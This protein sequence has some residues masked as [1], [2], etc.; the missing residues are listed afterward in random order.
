MSSEPLRLGWIGLGSMGFA[1]ALNIQK[2][3]QTHK[4]PPLHCWNRTISRGDPLR[5]FGSVLCESVA[6]VVQNSDVIFISV[7]ND[8]ALKSVV[9]DII[10]SG[11]IK[12]KI[13]VDTTTVH[14]NTSA[15]T[16]A[17]FRD[18][19]ADYIA[20]PVFGATPLAQAG[21]L[22]I[23]VAGPPTS[24]ALIRPFLAG[25]TARAV[26]DVGPVPQ[27]ALLLK[28]TSN[29]LTAGLMYLLSEAHT[30]AEK[31]G[32]PAAV[33]ESLVEQNFGAYAHG[34]S[35]RMTGGAY[36]PAE[37]QAPASGLGLAIKDVGHGVSVAMGVGMQLKAGEL[38]VAAME[39]AR[40]FG[41]AVGRE[42]DS[43]S[44]FG[45]VRQRAGL[46]FATEEVKRRDEMMREEKG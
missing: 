40:V 24:I 8:D 12:D 28:T 27:Q 11:P 18:A 5:A 34:V 16:T 9:D 6:E 39:E 21:A 42:L 31:A 46:E 33:L 1:M 3:L 13:I 22:L 20:A 23:A 15:A 4:L 35:A 32:L 2:H 25:V 14:P 30:L 43:S 36:F 7:S 44:V 19:H 10:T 29:F 26:I 41:G 17:Q 45:V 37:G 38:S